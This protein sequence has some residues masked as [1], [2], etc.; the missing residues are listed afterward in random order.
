MHTVGDLL[1]H[2]PRRYLSGAELTDLSTIE[3]G[4]HV[5][6]MA[7]VSSTN[8]VRGGG[9]R[10]GARGGPSSRLEVTLTDGDGYLAATF[11]GRE[12][13][14]D[15]WRHEWARSAASATSCR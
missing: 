10:R 15:Y 1:R 3:P 2:L 7:R 4:E 11:F 12:F 8:V 6:V 5:A 14:V 13:M 9:G